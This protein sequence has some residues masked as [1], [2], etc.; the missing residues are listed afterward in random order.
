MPNFSAAR[1]TKERSRDGGGVDRDLVGARAQ[2]HADVV[3]RAHAAAHGKRHE[4]ALRRLAHHVEDDAA[5]LVARADIEE[6]K[7]VG[8][9]LVVGRG[10]LDRIAGIAQID[11]VYALDHA[12]VFHVEAGDDA[13]FEHAAFQFIH[14]FKA[15]RARASALREAGP[16]V[17][18]VFS[19]MR[20]AIKRPQ[21]ISRIHARQDA[22][23]PL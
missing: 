9:G 22:L 14:N 19:V 15:L 12:A 10:G 5:L 11:E 2:Q 8:S 4:A 3:Q 16:R 6:A 20:A 17:F 21:K 13:H 23:K 18:I 7:L 1:A